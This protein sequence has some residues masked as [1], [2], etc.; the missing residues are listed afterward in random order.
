MSHF[1]AIGFGN[2]QN[3][4]DFGNLIDKALDN[5]TTIQNDY[6]IYQDKSG[7]E[8]WIELV[9]NQVL[10]AEPYFA[11]NEHQVAITNIRP[12]TN[13][14]TGLVDIW[15]NGETYIDD[16]TGETETIGDYP[17]AFEMADIRHFRPLLAKTV[18]NVRLC[19]FAEFA[20]IFED[21][22]EFDG[23]QDQSEI[24]YATHSFFP[25]G[26]FVEDDESAP[27]NQKNTVAEVFFI[28]HITDVQTKT[29]TLTGQ[30]FYCCDVE[31]YG[32]LWKA[33]YPFDM[34]EQSPK[35][36]NVVKG[37]YWVTGNLG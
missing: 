4:H 36:G 8:L 13:N 19:A 17:L 28:G 37:D 14:N 31:T 30:E 33:V 2:I 35:V 3:E 6:H 29:N 12:N 27:D 16:E 23:T 22:T 25:T 32:G 18:C 34:F 1:S 24:R 11:G 7:A 5:V 20:E 26:T 15:I 21:E 9:E 10:C